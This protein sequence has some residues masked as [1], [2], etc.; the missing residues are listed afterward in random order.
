MLIFD[1]SLRVQISVLFDCYIFFPQPA[2]LGSSTKNRRLYRIKWSRMVRCARVLWPLT[3]KTSSGCHV[4]TNSAMR[5]MGPQ[6]PLSLSQGW[7]SG[8][9]CNCRQL[10]L[11]RGF[12]KLSGICSQ[13]RLSSQPLLQRIFS[14]TWSPCQYL[15]GCWAVFQKSLTL[16]SSNL[17]MS[18]GI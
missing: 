5:L 15:R 14:H 8:S 12:C 17:I 3:T 10:W 18:V 11:W 1:P 2:S 7:A 9:M 16:S 4:T 6:T 13:P